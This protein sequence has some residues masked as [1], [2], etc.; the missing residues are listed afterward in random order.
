[1]GK[2]EKFTRN[3]YYGENTEKQD[4]GQRETYLAFYHKWIAPKT[5]C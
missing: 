1:M 3:K 4:Q 5:G 2:K